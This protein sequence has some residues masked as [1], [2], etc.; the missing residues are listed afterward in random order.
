MAHLLIPSPL[1]KFTA[2]NSR[3]EVNADSVWESLKA[4]SEDHPEIKD[5]IFDENG[6]IRPFLRLFIGETDTEDLDGPAT[7]VS[8]NDEISII[9]A[10]AGG[11]YENHRS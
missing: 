10:I 1:R 11:N 6:G 8:E 7:P 4:L 5:H 9:P 3:I 2:Q